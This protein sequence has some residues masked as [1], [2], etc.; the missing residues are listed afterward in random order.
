MSIVRVVLLSSLT[1]G[2]GNADVLKISVGN[3]QNKIANPYQEYDEHVHDFADQ[4]P[5]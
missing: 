2:L 4:L 1:T 5:S 3:Q